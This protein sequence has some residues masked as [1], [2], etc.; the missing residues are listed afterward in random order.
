MRK[1]RGVERAFFSE[2]PPNSLRTPGLSC[3]P[4]PQFPTQ[5][6][7]AILVR[8]SLHSKV[9]ASPIVGARQVGWTLAPQGAKDS[10]ILVD[11]GFVG[12]ALVNPWASCAQA[13]TEQP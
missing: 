1:E 9:W 10:A 6:L 2:V 13:P 3:L 7:G 8:K 11:Q 12:P 4:W 5:Q